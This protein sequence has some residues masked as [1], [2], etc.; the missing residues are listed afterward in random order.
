MYVCMYV[1][2]NTVSTFW[3]ECSN[4]EYCAVI[5]RTGYLRCGYSSTRSVPHAHWESSV[6]LSIT[7]NWRWLDA[8]S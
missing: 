5:W 2:M 4:C 1:C 3:F 6:L 8:I 7:F